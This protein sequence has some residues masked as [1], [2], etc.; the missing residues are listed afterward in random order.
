MKLRPYDPERDLP[1]IV[2]IHSEIGW[3]S[4][5]DADKRGTGLFQA[6]GRSLVAEVNGQIEGFA[7]NHDG[8]MRYLERDLPACIVGGVGTGRVARRRGIAQKATAE[9]LAADVIEKGHAVAALGMFDQGFYDQLGFGTG[10]PDTMVGFDPKDLRVRPPR[11]TP[12]RLGMDDA[13][14]MHASRMDVL[15]RHGSI[16]LDDPRITEGELCMN[17]SLAGFGLGFEAEP[18]GQITHHL[19]MTT[20]AAAQGPYAVRWMAYRD[21]EEML[22]LFGLLKGLADQVHTV[23]LVEPHDMPVWDLLERPWRRR[24]LSQGSKHESLSWSMPWYQVRV[25]DV[26]ACIAAATLPVDE[27]LRFNL[28]LTDPIVDLLSET[29]AARW[30]GVGGDYVVRLGTES[31]VEGREPDADLPTLRTSVNSF[32]RL[33][34][35]ALP[36][37]GLALTAPAFEA[38]ASLIAALD[39]VW[40]LPRPWLGWDI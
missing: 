2:R 1:E 15:R 27:P 23:R 20:A 17:E 4:T 28:A 25:C 3:P 26:E 21:R 35:G 24:A 6:S 39:R 16:V 29:T 14:R 18:G 32:S 31:A 22:D 33:W 12:V 9:A 37:S 7:S 10:A 30:G 36:A 11:L 8:S 40:R 5:T 19:W 13:E 38:P 34:Y